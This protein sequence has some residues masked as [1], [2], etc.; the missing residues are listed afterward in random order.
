MGPLVVQLSCLE[1]WISGIYC[2]VW[3]SFEM[4][5]FLGRRDIGRVPTFGKRELGHPN[6]C[7]YLMQMY[8]NF[9]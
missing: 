7:I 9:K 1:D 6:L 8:A 5:R 4:G 2:A 3:I